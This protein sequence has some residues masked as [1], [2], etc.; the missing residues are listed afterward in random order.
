[1]I[2]AVDDVLAG[3]PIDVDC[4]VTFPYMLPVGETLICTYSEDG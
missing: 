1:V 2:T 4:G 3:D